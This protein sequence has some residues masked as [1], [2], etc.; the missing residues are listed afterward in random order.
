MPVMKFLAMAAGLGALAL[1]GCTASDGN[2]DNFAYAG[3][4]GSAYDAKA[5]P[6]AANGMSLYDPTGAMPATPSDVKESSATVAGSP[7]GV[8][9]PRK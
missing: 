1:S 8:S 4:P 2:P 5:N 7:G 3:A 9:E 6:P